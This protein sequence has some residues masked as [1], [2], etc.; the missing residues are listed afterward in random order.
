MEYEKQLQDKDK[1]IAD[2][3]RRTFV[4]T[5]QSFGIDLADVVR[6]Y[7]E[8]FRVSLQKAR[9]DVKRYWVPAC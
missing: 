7:A 8:Q 5:A 6:K 9:Y 1:A 3:E 4:T 2:M